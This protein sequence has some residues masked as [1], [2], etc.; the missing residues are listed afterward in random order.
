MINETQSAKNP[1]PI[2]T[3][4]SITQTQIVEEPLDRHRE[5]GRAETIGKAK[6]N[7]SNK[8]SRGADQL[9]KKKLKYQQTKTYKKNQKSVD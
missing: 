9:T 6:E 7:A 3:P 2:V 8:K 1:L 4:Q 5:R